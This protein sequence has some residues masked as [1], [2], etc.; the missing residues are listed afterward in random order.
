MN[1]NTTTSGTVCFP[2]AG[3]IVR[4]TTNNLRIEVEGRGNFYIKA[5]D[6]SRLIWNGQVNL[7][8]HDNEFYTYAGNARLSRSGKAAMFFIGHS[9]FMSPLSLLKRLFQGTADKCI[10]SV[11]IDAEP[12]QSDIRAGLA[13]GFD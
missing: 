7:Y 13:T 10:L 1:T 11:Y 12:V 9:I 8:T 3:R 4:E 2:K 6:R 5:E